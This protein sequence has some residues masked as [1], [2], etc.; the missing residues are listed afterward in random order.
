[1]PLVY[2]SS[3]VD[4]RLQ[5]VLNAIDGGPGDGILTLLASGTV[6]SMLTLAKP[7]G[8]IAGGVLTFFSPLTDASAAGTGSVT[9]GTVSD[10]AGNLV[11]LNL[12]TGIPGAGADITIFN[13]MNSTQIEAGQTVQVLAA[14]ITGA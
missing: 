4:A 7:S 6:I 2:S 8:S 5:V 9:S 13:G 14:R 11:A 10:S 12:S 1:M 3:V